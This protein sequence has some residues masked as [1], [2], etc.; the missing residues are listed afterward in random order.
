MSNIHIDAMKH[1]FCMGTTRYADNMHQAI[2]YKIA[3]AAHIVH[4]VSGMHKDKQ[5]AMRDALSMA[6]EYAKREQK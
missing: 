6:I 4:G 2:A 3:G 1:G 5:T